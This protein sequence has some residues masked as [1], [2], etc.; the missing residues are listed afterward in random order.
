MEY[1]KKHANTWKSPEYKPYNTK[2]RKCR[3][4][5]A[6]IWPQN[7]TVPKIRLSGRPLVAECQNFCR[8]MSDFFAC[9]P[10]RWL[11]DQLIDRL[12]FAGRILEAYTVKTITEI[13]KNN[14][15][16]PYLFLR[17]MFRKKNYGNPYLFLRKSV[18]QYTG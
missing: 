10:F 6:L 1:N 2:I 14:Y 5:T 11:E 9:I 7:P 17:V 13:R 12:A 8:P 3:N 15:V 16:F 18:Y 4:A